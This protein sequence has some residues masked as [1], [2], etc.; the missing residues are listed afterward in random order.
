MTTE[1]D[2]QEVE[3]QV[4]LQA[5]LDQ[6]RSDLESV[7]AKKNEL[8]DETKQAKRDREEALNAVK[9]KE[10]SD[11]MN[12]GEFEKLLQQKTQE[13]E[14]LM[15]KMHKM[16]ES[17]KQEKI[18]ITAMKV[19][20]AIADG[21]NAEILSEF[22]SRKLSGLVDDSG[23]LSADAIDAVTEQFK[24]DAKFKS[25]LRAS[26]ATGGGAEGNTNGVHK[27]TK[28]VDRNAFEKMNPGKRMDYIK[29][30]GTVVDNI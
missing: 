20:T 13:N 9:A 2:N 7:V 28:T 16:N 18:N 21:D 25:L 22:V 10:E 4:D 29:N 23:V 17:S 1:L 3:N 30:G 12:N 14:E 11:A 15:Q 8:L 24:L 19:A 26:K 27:N 5:Q 6:M